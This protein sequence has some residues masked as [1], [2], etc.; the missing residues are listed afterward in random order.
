MK[1]RFRILLCISTF[2]FFFS[3]KPDITTK[4]NDQDIA[5]LQK[6]IQ[7]EPENHLALFARGKL[8]LQKGKVDSALSDLSSA[9]RIDSTKA[10][11]FIALADAQLMSN[12]SRFT[13]ISLLKAAQ[14]DTS[15]SEPHMKLAELYVYVEQYK[16][17]L[18]EVNQ[19]LRRDVKNPKGYYLK[20]IIFKYL[21]DTAKAMSSFLTT[22]DLDPDYV[23]AYEQMGLI[24]AARNDKKAI[25][26]YDAG[27]KRNSKNPQLL[28]NKAYF[29]QT[30][31][32]LD[33]AKAN[34]KAIL[35]LTQQF[36]KAY[37]NL[38]YLAFDENNLTEALNYF[39]RA[40]QANPMYA[41]AHYMEGYCY[42]LQKDKPNAL[43][44]YEKTLAIKPNHELALAAIDRLKKK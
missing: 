19:A 7:K 15:L 38:G 17:A 31:G 44:K 37:Y 24:H 3:C 9:I 13:K 14:L 40:V 23:N 10:D 22:T 32:Q 16:D 18:S 20:G 26:F 30:I 42:E 1:T 29:Y 28:Y 41:D 34:Y 21:G 11:Y 35:A 27:L 6:L 2:L 39:Q 5:E 25:D 36:S 33:S 8:Y 12:R 43:S 4:F